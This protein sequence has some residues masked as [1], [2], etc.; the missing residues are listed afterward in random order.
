MQKTLQRVAY[1]SAS[2]LAT[3]ANVATLEEMDRK[4]K[5]SDAELD[6]VNKQLDEAQGKPV[7]KCIVNTVGQLRSGLYAEH[8]VF[9]D[10]SCRRGGRGLKAVLKMAEAEGGQKESG[11]RKGGGRT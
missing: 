5:R 10:Y 11:C 4:L 3:T 8:M 7:S 2:S 9:G 1:P 6:L